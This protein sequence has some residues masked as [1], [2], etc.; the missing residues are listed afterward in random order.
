MVPPA[1]VPED[2]FGELDTFLRRL[3]GVVAR[4]PRG[5]SGAALR[6]FGQELADLVR[7]GERYRPLPL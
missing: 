6:R 7:E 3:K 5:G 1:D 2:R 4:R